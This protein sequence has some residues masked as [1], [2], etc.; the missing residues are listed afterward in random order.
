ML[1]SRRERDVIVHG[2]VVSASSLLSDWI[3]TGRR[4]PSKTTLISENLIGAEE[5]WP[6]EEITSW[7]C[8]GSPTFPSA[9]S[10][11]KHA[12]TA[13]IK[14]NIRVILVSRNTYHWIRHPQRAEQ[15]MVLVSP[16]ETLQDFGECYNSMKADG[17]TLSVSK[18]RIE[19]NDNI[20]GAYLY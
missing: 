11:T 17:R 12:V 8:R 5:E 15:Q 1:G 16:V 19:V 13:R 6:W 10:N 14:I 4:E 3:L 9:L 20:S 18:V 2:V 7:A